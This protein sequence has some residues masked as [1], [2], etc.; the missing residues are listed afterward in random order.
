[1][2]VRS[3]KIAE[4]ASHLGEPPRAAMLAALMDGRALTATE[5]ACIAGITPQ[6]GSSHLARLTTAQLLRVER[7][8]RHRYYRIATSEVAHTVETIMQLAS[9]A[10]PRVRPLTVGL[11]DPALRAARL[12]E[13]H[14][15]GRLGVAIA[16]ALVRRGA[17]E[18]DDD[19]GLVTELGI[20]L[21]RRAGIELP[22]MR[23]SGGHVSRI[24]CRPCLDWSE[25]RVHIAGKLGAA[26]ARHSVE[27]R[28]VRRMVD[29]R[30][31][32]ITASGRS[33]LHRLFR[34]EKLE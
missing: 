30:A 17:I 23:Q 3:D 6:T 13:D 4:I 18:L 16:E 20:D 10:A 14:L 21:L 33:A 24:L 26:V 8:G 31:L 22:G 19:A 7:Q 1:M 27:Q 32:E 9:T 29:T 12:C 5:L 15:A 28:W 25:R 2:P 11:R 34:V